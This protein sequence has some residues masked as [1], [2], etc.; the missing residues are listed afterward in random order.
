MRNTPASPRCVVPTAPLRSQSPRGR[1]AE[2]AARRPAGCPSPAS[3]SL[4]LSSARQ[5]ARRTRP[6]PYRT[7]PA[8]HLELRRPCRRQPAS[9]S[10][11]PREQQVLPCGAHLGLGGHQGRASCS[12]DLVGLGSLGRSRSV[13]VNGSVV[14]RRG[15]LELF[16]ANVGELGVCRLKRRRGGLGRRA[17]LAHRVLSGRSCRGGAPK[18]LGSRIVSGLSLFGSGVSGLLGLDGLAGLVLSRGRRGL[19]ILLGGKGRRLTRSS[20]ALRSLRG[21]QLALEL[22][23]A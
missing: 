6:W 19:G 11:P 2:D 12:Q 23:G 4:P 20:L 14:A 13:S 22:R 1:R 18:L 15:S 16:A 3:K 21:F 10:D 17:S 9:R 8:R 5:R 7:P